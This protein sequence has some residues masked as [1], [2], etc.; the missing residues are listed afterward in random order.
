VVLP[1]MAIMTPTGTADG[2]GVRP[3]D[4]PLAIACE[5]RPGRRYLAVALDADDHYLIEFVGNNRVVATLRLGPVPPHRRSPGLATYVENLPAAAQRD[6][7]DTIIIAPAS[8]DRYRVGHL[9]LDGET[10]TDAELARLV[11]ARDGDTSP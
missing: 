7:F 8:G 9:L 5:N 10:A 6:G 2:P 1:A 4:T 11:A 3:I